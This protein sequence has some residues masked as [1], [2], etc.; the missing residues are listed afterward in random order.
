MLAPTDMT[1]MQF[2]GN[3]PVTLGS[4]LFP[5]AAITI[6]PRDIACAMA[7]CRYVGQESAGPA[8]DM[9][10]TLAGVGFA[11]N[12]SMAPPAEYTTA[13]A[14]SLAYPELQSPRTRMGMTV[15]F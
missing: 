10:M 8:R 6:A 5:A 9:L 3:V 7:D 15:Q 12:P 13:S 1:P 11:S 14:R 4:P 2:A